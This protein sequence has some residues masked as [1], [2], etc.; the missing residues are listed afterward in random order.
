MT[1]DNELKGKLADT[2]RAALLAGGHILRRGFNGPRRVRYKSPTNPVTEVDLAS[3]RAILRLIRR[4]FPSHVF[5]AEESAHSKAGVVRASHP[6]RYRWIIDPL[7][8]TVNYVHRLPQSSV[9]VAVERNGVILTGGVCD[10]L[11]GELFLASRGGGA[12]MNGRR[13]HVSEAPTIERSLLVTGFPY[14]HRQRP[15]FYL[16]YLRPFL[17]T[18]MDL[19]RFGSAALDLS[20][21]A[22]GRVDGYWE[23]HLNPWDVA[24][25]LLLVQEAGGAVSD[26]AGGPMDLDAPVETLA[27]NGKI[28]A[29]M[30]RH[31]RK[32]R[33][34]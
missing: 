22:C 32:L 25:G 10:P 24:A 2:V 13:I 18:A 14:D 6:D 12:T 21:I 16:R 20:W 31:L 11:R 29:A 27:T 26:F 17:K 34:R 30:L 9:S 7:D 19:R 15:D 28:H 4:R 8:G 23:H 33:R 1:I 3:E 5:L